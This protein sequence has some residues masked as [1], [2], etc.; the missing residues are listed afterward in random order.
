MGRVNTSAVDT[1]GCI[2][3]QASSPPTAA[4]PNKAVPARA[5]TMP[6]VVTA[7]SITGTP[8]R[9]NLRSNRSKVGPGNVLARSL[10][11]A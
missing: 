10:H 11:G 5:N 9:T 1:D 2:D 3:R 8:Q 7:S 6:S 4:P